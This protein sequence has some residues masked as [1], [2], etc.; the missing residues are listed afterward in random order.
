MTTVLPSVR[1]IHL[2]FY[3]SF[4]ALRRNRG[5]VDGRVE[6]RDVGDGQIAEEPYPAVSLVVFSSRCREPPT[7]LVIMIISR[8]STEYKKRANDAMGQGQPVSDRV[9]LNALHHR[10]SSSFFRALAFS[11]C[12][13]TSI[14]TSRKDFSRIE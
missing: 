12:I 3:G 8:S 4:R 13:L 6:F 9:F 2:P 7:H 5:K 10:S 14:V 1:A 11:L